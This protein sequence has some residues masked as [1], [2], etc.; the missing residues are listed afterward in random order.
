MAQRIQTANTCLQDIRA[1]ENHKD[2]YK[3]KMKGEW[4]I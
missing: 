2:T 3:K 1:G 4:R